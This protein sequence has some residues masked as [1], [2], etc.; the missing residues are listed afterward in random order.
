MKIKLKTITPIHIGTGK[1]L[2]PLDFFNNSRID[3]D[4]LFELLS[5][6][7]KDEFFEWL[8]SVEVRS[9]SVNA[10]QKKFNIKPQEIINNCSLYRFN[11]S[12][13]DKVRESIKDSSNRIFIPGSSL[14]GTI[15]TALLYKVLSSK[16]ELLSSHI[17]NLV[18]KASKFLEQGRRTDPIKK[19]ADDKLEEEIFICGVKKIIH[20]QPQVVYSDQKYDLLKLLYITDSTSVKTDESGEISDIKVYVLKKNA[21]H[22]NYPLFAESISKNTILEFDISFDIEFL[23][24]A[25][26][27]LREKN[28]DFGKK[29][30]IGIEDKLKDLFDIDIMDETEFSEEKIVNGIIKSLFE[31]GSA[32]SECG[33]IQ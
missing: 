7:K 1:E 28:N 13:R 20:N 26:A 2:T 30:F 18:D 14:K 3:Y 32:V 21:P 11:Q 5:V 23:K 4:K 31:Y 27:L 33:W 16:S 24:K 6:E 10:I 15:R 29:Y 9:F 19:S 12:F 25:Q 17:Q 22:S 8:D